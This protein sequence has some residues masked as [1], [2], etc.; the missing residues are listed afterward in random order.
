VDGRSAKALPGR[1]TDVQ[2]CQWIRD[3][4]MHGLLRECVVPEAEILVLR[5]YWRQ[6]ERV[7][8]ER[9]EQMQL[10][11][12]AMEQM[13]IQIHKVLSD[14]SGVSGLAMI[15]AI[16]D[17]E[18]DPKALSSRLVGP[19]KRKKDLVEKALEGNW[20]E[21]HLFALEQAVATYDFLGS[22]LEMCER[23]LE[24]QMA[25]L[26]GGPP[27]SPARPKASKNE[28]EFDMQIHLTKMLGQDATA[29]DG[30]SVI[31]VATIV[32]ELGADLSR[33]KTEKHFVSYLG[34]AP[35][36]KITGGN[37]KSSRTRKVTHRVANALRLA[38]QALHSSNSALGAYS[39][40]MKA[41]IGAAKAT[42]A[43]ARKLAV[44][45]YRL[46]VHGIQYQDPGEAAYNERFKAQR[47]KSL[48]KQAAK[49]GL[50][51]VDI[52]QLAPQG[53]FS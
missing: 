43:T 27:N 36:N 8:H 24:A 25:A 42:T 4:H 41:R 35:V 39:R 10:M 16:L 50:T 23:R 13:N 30:L 1:K 37:I 38:A 49:F 46:T 9:S 45:Y 29:I 52:P 33:F 20:A 31:T 51:L 48:T 47:I 15:R 3:L 17:G 5:S 22:R 2:D 7:I 18:R 44:M 28:P 11:Q 19:A 6:R 32:S 21:H 12:K 53:G 34:L 40:R 14:I 26:S